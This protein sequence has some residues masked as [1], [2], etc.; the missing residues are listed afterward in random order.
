MRILIVLPLVAM[1]LGVSSLPVTVRTQPEEPP[2]RTLGRVFGKLRT[3]R[4][5][6]VAFLGGSAT[7]G[8]G[9]KH[10]D[11][12][13]FPALVTQWLRRQYPQNRIEY[14]NAGVP[15]TGALYGTLRLRRD[16]LSLKP[17]LVLIELTREDADED[18]R[19]V[20][21]AIEGILR[22]L[23]VQAEPPEVL[24]LAASSTRADTSP[25]TFRT[26]AAHY[27]IP[28]LDLWPATKELSAPGRLSPASLYNRDHELTDY[29]HRFYADR[30]IGF[31][32]DQTGR[33]ET[34]IARRLPPPLVSD[35]LNYGEFRVLAEFATG[36]DWR[37]E[38]SRSPHLPTLLLV[39]DRPGATIEA[40]FEGTVVGLTWLRGP[41]AGSFE[42]LIDGRPASFPL[43]RIDC[44][45]E[46]ESIGTAVIP[47]GLG[48]GEHRLTIRLVRN[49]PSRQGGRKVRL[50]FLLVGGQRPERL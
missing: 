3:G 36:K 29:G 16:L 39:S 45:A 24:L 40:V 21:K 35:E 19:I 27:G 4:A 34:P 48:L 42:V 10:P 23:L 12:A 50:G 31:M 20:V 38:R 9:T 47:G 46:R 28:V 33:P 49:Q 15:A 14:I 44:A 1:M 6:T 26:V 13:S 32:H 37:L 7:S 17:D 5:V 25:T 41:S 18:Q 22:Q 2:A 30:I 43:N 11:R 8:I